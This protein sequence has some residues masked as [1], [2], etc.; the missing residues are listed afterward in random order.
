MK[1]EDLIR[2][3]ESFKT[4]IKKGNLHDA[5]SML[6]G[7]SE[8]MMQWEISDRIK[9]LE[10]NYLLM[11]DYAVKGVADENRSIFAEELG[12]E[13]NALYTSL[14]IKSKLNEKSYEIFMDLIRQKESRGTLLELLSK[15]DSLLN[16]SSEEYYSEIIKNEEDI[17]YTIW[18]KQYISETEKNLLIEIFKRN[19]ISETLKNLVLGAILLNFLSTGYSFRLQ[20]VLLTVYAKCEDDKW[21]IRALTIAFL[22]LFYF[23]DE[24]SNI[25]LKKRL[26]ELENNPSLDFI[27]DARNIIIEIVR[28]KETESISKKI[29]EEII[30]TM[31][32]M[33]PSMKEHLKDLDEEGL[34]S[35]E[36]NPE[37]KKLFADSGLQGKLEE[38]NR[39]QIEGADVLMGSFGQL[40]SFP[41]FNNVHNW[42]LPFDANRPEI[43]DKL[44]GKDKLVEIGSL[45][46]IFCD[47][48][49]YSFVFA[50]DGMPSL[51]KEQTLNVMAEQLS[52]LSE[53]KSNN[54]RE[55]QNSKTIAN[56]YI[57]DLYRFFNLY[58]RKSEFVNPFVNLVNPV[59][60]KI[61]SAITDNKE[62][63]ENLSEFYLRHKLWEDAIDTYKFM[64][65]KFDIDSQLYQKL[66][67]A[68]QMSGDHESAL[69][70]Y[71][72]A[73]IL[74][75]SS[76]WVW[77][78]IALCSR[79]LG[80]WST[81]IEYYKKLEKLNENDYKIAMALGNLY[82]EEG[83]FNEARKQ[84]YKADYLEAESGKPLRKIIISSLYLG[85]MESAGRHLKRLSPDNPGHEDLLLWGHYHYKSG[86]F[87]EALK[88]YVGSFRKEGATSNNFIRMLEQQHKLLSR[89]DDEMFN[90]LVERL[91]YMI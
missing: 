15:Q 9:T 68:Y 63:L 31:M 75:P 12:E 3:K 60:I 27:A 36:E 51:Q 17:F 78:K 33:G 53:M 32:K 2:E 54:D 59:K 42:F 13:L 25:R 43:K 8:S 18:S 69:N 67:Y 57:K 70:Y 83:D 77:R 41:F 20:D 21:R 4:L 23:H 80:K 81:A 46:N 73:D 88:F 47:S 89:D 30:P 90:M 40:K 26:A 1:L 48:D 24:L 14:I 87:E 84:F 56:R 50:I 91:R 45:T 52:A 38:L 62:F 22:V 76:Q 58:R 79:I 55:E 72:H 65:T 86:E 82:L 34:L 19:D 61:L 66:G 71:L 44:S 16:I 29:L 11:L 5:F 85:D 6:L 49:M 10:G 74:D 37:W 39:M 28:T 7:L 64:E 35:L